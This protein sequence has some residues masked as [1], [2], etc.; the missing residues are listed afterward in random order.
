MSRKNPLGKKEPLNPKEA[1]LKENYSLDL[2][3]QVRD[4]LSEL[5]SYE[6]KDKTIFGPSFRRLIALIEETLPIAKLDHQTLED[7]V[8]HLAGKRL[9]QE[10]IQETSHRLAG[11]LPRLRRRRAVIPWNGQR[12]NEWVPVQFMAC[13]PA[14][15][16]RKGPGVIYTLKILAGTPCPRTVLQR[17]SLKKCAYLASFMGYMRSRRGVS[18]LYPYSA[19]EQLVTLRLLAHID[20]K[21]SIQEPIITDY[22]ATESLLNWNREQIKRRLARYLPGY[23]CPHGFA[24][25]FPCHGCFFGYESCSAATH[26][27]D[28]VLRRCPQ[29]KEAKAPFDRDVSSEVCVVC[30]REKQEDPY[31]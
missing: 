4:Q 8:R 16:N 28:Y 31:A 5:L 22:Q 20:R 1:T 29:C 21:A 25:D 18:A 19:P 17:W 6:L 23:E 13:R 30:Y 27:A 14:K 2:V 24:H 11:N 12:V 7:S 3:F 15:P 10:L 9:T 26:P